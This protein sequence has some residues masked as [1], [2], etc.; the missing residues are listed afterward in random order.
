LF[1]QSNA[2]VFGDLDGLGQ[3]LLFE[4]Q[5]EFVPSEAAGHGL[6]QARG[7]RA[8]SNRLV[9]RLMAEGIVDLLEVVYIE[10]DGRDASVRRSGTGA[11]FG[12]QLEKAAPI[13]QAGQRI[14]GCE[15]DQFSLHRGNSLGG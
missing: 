9:A 10:N 12:G 1:S 3:R 14:D 8:G 4:D 13:A 15:P 2:K 11:G 5:R 7:A 6:L